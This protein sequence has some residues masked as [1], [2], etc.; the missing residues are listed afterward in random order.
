MKK[1]FWAVFGLGGWILAAWL[2]NIPTAPVE[3]R[4]ELYA[5]FAEAVLHNEGKPARIV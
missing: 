5:S 1:I 2:Y 4:E 3:Y